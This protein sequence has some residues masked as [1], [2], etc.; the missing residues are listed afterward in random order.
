[1]AAVSKKASAA[2]RRI[3]L[4]LCLCAWGPLSF[5]RLQ[6]MLPDY[7]QGAAGGG[8][9]GGRSADAKA[10][11]S[12]RRLFERDKEA[13]AERGVFIDTFETGGYV[14]RGM[15]RPV[16]ADGGRLEAGSSQTRILRASCS[17]LL[18]D[19]AYPHGIALRGAMAKLSRELEVPDSIAWS[20]PT[21]LD[22][23]QG[24]K[25]IPRALQRKVEQ[26]LA[27]HKLLSFEYT[28]PR[29]K[30][31]RCVEPMGLFSSEGRSYLVAWDRDKQAERCF[32][33]DRMA[34]ARVAGSG[35]GAADYEPRAFDPE[36]WHLLP[37]QMGGDTCKPQGASVSVLPHALWQAE[38]LCAGYGSVML[39]AQGGATWYVDCYDPSLLAEWCI[40]NGPGLLPVEPPQASAAYERLLRE[41]A[42]GG[43]V[44]R[45][46]SGV[47]LA[48]Q[49]APAAAAK[50]AAPKPARLRRS[51]LRTP[52]ADAPEDDDVMFACL[53]L[54]ENEGVVSLPQTARFLSVEEDAVYD[55]LEALAFCYD[56]AGIHLELGER[57]C[58]FA[59]LLQPAGLP[60]TLADAEQEALEDAA[61]TAQQDAVARTL[62]QACAQDEA[63]WLELLYWK[64]G[65]PQAQRRVVLPKALLTRDGHT[66]LQAH[67]AR[68]CGE[69]LFRLDRI[70]AATP[71]AAAP[72]GEDADM[73]A[74]TDSGTAAAGIEA[75]V[76][77]QPGCR[78][79]D[80]PG[81][82]LPKKRAVDGTLNVKVTWLQ[83]P[84][85]PKHVASL[86][87]A[88][89][90][91]EPPTLAQEAR[92]YACS[93]LQEL[94]ANE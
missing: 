1:M 20:G 43:A 72:D 75:C 27:R 14:L 48:G 22:A 66:Y 19:A 45:E 81:A 67:C 4:A 76:T 71:L 38:K 52:A 69:R 94:A 85:L 2:E 31:L 50:A 64:E 21:A 32:R 23:L 28:G 12:A 65:E 79:P 54:L 87:A 59:R 41:T 33:L 51:A 92:A 83:S 40:A 42:C 82:R 58:S 93:L 18:Q 10:E 68:A 34:K 26:A 61:Q 86:G 6:H 7:G 55:A 30:T 89:L 73:A 91:V 84:W 39:N 77:L 37:F 16:L 49:T 24:G 62:A 36:R 44:A 8:G 9:A 88:A 3:K 46:N 13:L 47:A 80:W 63:Q 25:D 11:T 15:G 57:G 5:A 74:T 78:V 70:E 56:A 90:H 35:R 60:L 29:G 53:A 17:A